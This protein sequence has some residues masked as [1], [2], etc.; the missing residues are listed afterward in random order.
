[1]T[2]FGLFLKAIGFGLLGCVCISFLLHC[3]VFILAFITVRIQRLREH[4][5]EPSNKY[6][7]D[8]IE[9]G[10]YSND[11]DNKRYYACCCKYLLDSYCQIWW[12]WFFRCLYNIKKAD[13]VNKDR[14]QECSNGFINQV[15]FEKT[16]NKVSSLPKAG[17]HH[18]TL[19][20]DSED[21]QPNANKTLRILREWS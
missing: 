15:V 14:N 2:Y 19:P 3:L 20:Q 18:D 6:Y 1:M 4:S 11:G 7:P 17:S 12:G 5:F 16:Q 9:S 13:T 21:K 10:K 8:L